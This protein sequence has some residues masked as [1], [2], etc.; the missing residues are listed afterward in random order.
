M[1]AQSRQGGLNSR[2]VAASQAA[3]KLDAPTPKGLRAARQF[4]R[5]TL[6]AYGMSFI[7][8]DWS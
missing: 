4:F 8:A 1:L 6:C 5:D 2:L 3:K 7:A